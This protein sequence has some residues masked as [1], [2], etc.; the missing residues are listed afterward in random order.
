MKLYLLLRGKISKVLSK[1]SRY[2][3]VR[4]PQLGNRTQGAQSSDLVVKF[5]LSDV[6]GGFTREGDDLVFVETL[7]L[8]QAFS[9]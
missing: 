5:R 6:N 8:I 2:F 4:F 9:P 1:F 3:D 7:T